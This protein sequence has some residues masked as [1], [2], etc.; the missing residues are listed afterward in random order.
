MLNPNIP[1]DYDIINSGCSFCSKFQFQYKEVCLLIVLVFT[2]YM[3]VCVY[4]YSVAWQ[5][6]FDK[7]L[8]SHE[9][10]GGVSN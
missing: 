3:F 5:P 2:C 4:L 9:R 10:G 7:Q 1:I 6:I 8:S